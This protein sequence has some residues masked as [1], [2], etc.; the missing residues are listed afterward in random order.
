M[1][2]MQSEYLTVEEFGAIFKISKWTVYKL[3]REGRIQAG[4]IT[5]R[6]RPTFRIH[7]SQVSA[8][9]TI[10]ERDADSYLG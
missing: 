8:Y 4:I 1:R 5:L 7:Q 3:I 10:I 6:K 2:R 9:K